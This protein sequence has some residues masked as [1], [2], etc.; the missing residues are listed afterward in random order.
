MGKDSEV[1]DW[2]R[3][4]R[5]RR[6]RKP[7]LNFTDELALR[8]SSAEITMIAS[9]FCRMVDLSDD[10]AIAELPKEFSSK[11]IRKKL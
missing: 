1:G 2:E 9:V 3:K 11:G 8:G 5:G 10:Q 7:K 6:G 4:S